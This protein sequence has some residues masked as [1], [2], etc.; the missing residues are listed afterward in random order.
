MIRVGIKLSVADNENKNVIFPQT[1]MKE[2]LF[3][4]DFKQAFVFLKVDPSKETWGDIQCEVFVKPGNTTQISTSTGGY[5]SSGNY[6]NGSTYSTNMGYGNVMTTQ[7]TTTSYTPK[8]VDSSD[9]TVTCVN[10]N[11][12]CF[13]GETF[14][15]KCGKSVTDIEETYN[16]Q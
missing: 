4:N 10:C 9:T 3:A 5:G 7:T 8:G 2:N 15:G 14:C 6:G 12:D 1:Q 13:Y 16:Y 11:D